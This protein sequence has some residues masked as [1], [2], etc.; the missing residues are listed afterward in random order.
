M[1]FLTFGRS[2]AGEE[3]STYE[4]RME[5]LSSISSPVS[6]YSGVEASRVFRKTSKFHA[7]RLWVEK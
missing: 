1:A 4:I 5:I 2:K 7:S 3:D 6:I